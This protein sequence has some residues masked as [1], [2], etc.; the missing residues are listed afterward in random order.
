MSPSDILGGWNSCTVS[1]MACSTTCTT[2]TPFA[3]AEGL[4]RSTLAKAMPAHMPTAS[5]SVVQRIKVFF[6]ILPP[7][8]KYRYVHLS[9]RKSSQQPDAENPICHLRKRWET[10]IED[11]ISTL[12][13]TTPPTG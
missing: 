10:R 13:A 5:A 7:L 11:R 12:A 4:L 2:V 6:M 1:V 3:L 8:E 9:A